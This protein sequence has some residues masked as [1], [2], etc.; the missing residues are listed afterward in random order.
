MRSPINP[1]HQTLS[2]TSPVT[3][4]ITSAIKHPR[5][6]LNII[7]TSRRIDETK[8]NLGASRTTIYASR[9]NPTIHNTNHNHECP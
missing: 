4:N 8:K 6:N 9:I 5:E 3:Y 2:N 1:S 7:T